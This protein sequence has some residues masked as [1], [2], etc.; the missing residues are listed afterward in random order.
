MFKM[1]EKIKV[2]LIFWCLPEFCLNNEYYCL[3]LSLSSFFSDW[4]LLFILSN[5]EKILR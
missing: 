3:E 4:F 2:S 5:D 1:Y